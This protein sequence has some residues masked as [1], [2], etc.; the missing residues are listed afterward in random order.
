MTI[1]PD[2]FKAAL[3]KFATGI[4]VVTCG[5]DDGP[6]G[7]TASAFASLS[8]DPPLILVNLARTS[9]TLSLIRDRGSFAVNILRGDQEEVSRAFAR[10]GTKSFDGLIARTGIDGAPLLAGA[11]A[12]LE[13][14]TDRIVDAG[15]HVIVLGEVMECDAHEGP[16]LLYFEQTYSSPSE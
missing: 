8:L 2:R 16:P 6:H 3:R 4:T 9:H 13:C 10:R 11:I 5:G 15:D 14:R 7:M 1:A 12:W